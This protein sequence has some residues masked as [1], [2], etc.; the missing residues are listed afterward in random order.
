[1]D[2]VIEMNKSVNL[3]N[4]TDPEEFIMKHYV[5]SLALRAFDEYRSASTVIDIGTGAGFPG[6]PLAVMDE[7]KEFV[8]LETLGK[9]VKI[10]E[11]LSARA[12]IANVKV[13]KARAEDAGRDKAYREKFDLAVSRAVADMAVLSE[14]CLPFVKVGGYFAAYKTGNDEEINGAKKAIATLGGKI[15]RVVDSGMP[16]MEHDFVMV[17]KFT[18]TGPK[19]PRQAGKPA[20]QPLR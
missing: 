15:R 16:G 11:E 17:E 20:K 3:T 9:R 1:M 7:D 18:P 14:Y 10:I 5:D 12:G 2:G 6:I 8:L 19:Y 4:I 13:I